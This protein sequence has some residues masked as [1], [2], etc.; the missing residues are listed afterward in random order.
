M[1]MNETTPL[2]DGEKETGR[3][4]AFSDGVFAIAITLLILEIRV[5]HVEG[6]TRN[7]AALLLEQWPS[8]AAYILSF[9]VIAVMWVNHHN[10]FRYIKRIDNQF[11]FI[12]SLLLMV[13]TALNFSTA[14]LADYILDPANQQVAGMVYAGTGFVIALLFNWLWKHASTNFRLLDRTL[15]PGLPQAITDQYR[16]GPLLYV[17]AFLLMFISVWLGVGLMF[18]LAVFFSLT[19]SSNNPTKSI[20]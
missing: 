6:E 9:L 19:G 5:P 4:E 12:N 8:Y 1:S 7:L 20:G 13:I 3:T 18:A 14:L 11:L 17:V 15:D 16:F 2:Q 10:M